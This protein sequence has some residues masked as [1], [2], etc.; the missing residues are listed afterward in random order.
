MASGVG[1][2]IGTG[3]RC[4]SASSRPTAGLAQFLKGFPVAWEQ[5]R[6]ALL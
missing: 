4:S 1:N 6:L 2:A 3:A 5:Q